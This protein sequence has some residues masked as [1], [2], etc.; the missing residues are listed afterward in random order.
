MRKI[1]IRVRKPEMIK[2]NDSYF[3]P[4]AGKHDQSD[5][6]FDEAS[7]LD[8]PGFGTIICALDDEEAQTRSSSFSLSRRHSSRTG[9]FA[10]VQV[11]LLVGTA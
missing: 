1:R 7:I 5:S 3:A 4:F 11:L 8:L 6:E 10:S 2:K 9:S